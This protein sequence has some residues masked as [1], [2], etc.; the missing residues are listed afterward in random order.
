MTAAASPS[1]ADGLPLKGLALL[2]ALAV[3]WGTAWPVM[4]IAMAELP[5]FA[6]RGTCIL[7]GAGFLFLLARLGRQPLAVPR[8]LWPR[9]VLAALLNVTLWNV[10][11][12]T[13]TLLLPAGRASVLFYTTPVWA[14]VLGRLV[15]HEPL[16]RRRGLGIALGVAAVAVLV[17][18]DLAAVIAAPAG[19]ACIL[20]GSVGWAAGAVVLKGF[21]P[22][23]PT[24]VLSAWQL[25]ISLPVFLA[26]FLLLERHA[27]HPISLAAALALLYTVI[28]GFVFGYWAWFRLV[29]MVPVVVSSIGSLCTPM[30]AVL[31]SI[32]LTGERPGPPELVALAL[33][34]GAILA[35]SLPA[36]HGR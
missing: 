24:T 9:L 34:A 3:L 5:L 32:W 31:A 10:L 35:V 26:G 13:G 8:R 14:S 36:R 7:V 19:V 15:L 29:R 12:P 20:L 23:I 21:P 1:R 16:G 33:V 11:I 22:S 18:G 28:L 4:K 25:I 27:L 17:G 2:A 30:V 6:F